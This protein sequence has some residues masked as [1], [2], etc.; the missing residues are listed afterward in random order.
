MTRKW[1]SA[2]FLLLSISPGLVRAQTAKGPLPAQEPLSNEEFMARFQPE[3][4]PPDVVLP[5]GT[6]LLQYRR[7]SLGLAPD[8]FVA[9]LIISAA[10]ANGDSQSSDY[11]FNFGTGAYGLT[12]GCHMAPAYLPHGYLTATTVTIDNFFIFA[13][14]NG[15]AGNI[16]FNLWRKDTLDTS[17]PT[18]M[19]T[20]TT[21]GASTSVQVLGDTTVVNPIVSEEYAYYITWCRTDTS[22]SVLGFWIFY[23]ES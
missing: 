12:D 14:D 13:V 23:T 21:I 18:I 8:Q 11:F 2:I 10:D 7:D 1:I 15:A 19:A 6:D 20:V 16:N 5:P 17:S 22:Q 9:P 4:T 3:A